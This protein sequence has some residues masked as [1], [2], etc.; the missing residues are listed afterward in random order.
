MIE[1][2]ISQSMYDDRMKELDEVKEN[3]YKENIDSLT[4]RMTRKKQ[5]NSWTEEDELAYKEA[6]KKCAELI[7][8]QES[9][10]ILWNADKI[11]VISDEEYEKLVSKEVDNGEQ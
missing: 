9:L 10:Q 5:N 3:I 8:E 4:A 11:N 1:R 2:T 7:A 6:D